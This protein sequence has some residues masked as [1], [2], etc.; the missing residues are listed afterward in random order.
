[1]FRSALFGLTA[2]LLASS[3]A[4]A[5]S[6][7]VPI[8]HSTRLT[9]GGAAASVLVGNPEV[10]DVTVVDSHTLFVLGRGY[11]ETDVVV[12]DAFGATLFSGE[13]IVAAPSSGRVSVYRGGERTDH[14]CAPG[15]Q[16]SVRSPTNPSAGGTVASGPASQSAGSP[17]AAAGAA[18][19]A[20]TAAN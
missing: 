3:S 9:V 11:G 12:L 8:D 19:A 18:G 13:V 16:V 15:C 7:V 2:G 20:A 4:L 5:A 14:A 1:M 6:L 17:I 10:A